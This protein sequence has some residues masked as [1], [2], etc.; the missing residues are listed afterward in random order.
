[1]TDTLFELPDNGPDRLAAAR[2]RLAA[3][4]ANLARAELANEELPI[5]LATERG[6]VEDAERELRAAE[7][8][9]TER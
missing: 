2:K 9:R 6:A 4:E 3:A 1:M 8:E 5:G 7:L